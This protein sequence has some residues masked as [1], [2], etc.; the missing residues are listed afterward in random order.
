M[1]PSDWFLVELPSD[2]TPG[3]A[4]G[5]R[6]LAAKYA[7]IAEVAGEASDGVTRA[8]SSG[9]A[10]AWIGDAADV[11][12]E[13]S[14][15]M[16]GELAQAN[17]SY[18]VVAAALKVWADAVD[19][20]QAQADRGLQQ[21]RDAQ[22][23]RM[24]A[25]AVLASAQSS[26]STV[27][28]QQLTY[29]RLQKNYASVPPP[30]GVALPTPDQLR[31]AA[32][33]ASQ[34]QASIAT[35]QSR[36]ADADARLAAAR[37]LVLD[38]KARRDD[39]E[40]TIVHRI[41]EA[42]D[43]AVKPSSAWE[44]IQDSAAWQTL[45][46]VATVVLTIVSIVAIFVTGPLIW[47]IILAATLLLIVNAL[48]SIAQGKDAWGEF[49]LLVVGIIPG[50][51]LLGL[52]VRGLSRAGRAGVAVAHGSEL[53]AKAASR[54]IE[55]GS[56]IKSEIPTELQMVVHRLADDRGS[57]DFF[58]RYEDVRS[59]FATKFSQRS[60]SYDKID[61]ATHEPYTY[62][63]LAESMRSGGWQGKPINAVDLGHHG[64]TSLDNTRLMAARETNTAA[65]VVIHHPD[66]LLT[67]REIKRFTPFGSILKPETWG[68]ALDLRILNQK[69]PWASMNPYGTHELPTVTGRRS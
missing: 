11:F 59:P 12:R 55:I 30:A 42:E 62:D 4:F 64:V 57:I 24:S 27:H 36:I 14:Y 50:G 23:D 18:S 7:A 37:S 26:W 45:V 40:R 28:A 5:V 67:R 22:A 17:D 2:P 25:A 47:A 19:D 51:R 53:I 66:E 10:S 1:R 46:A 20:T 68:D 69:E 39:A 32:R 21:A 65:H 63:D 13:K 44:A 16:P 54:I 9:A 43:R 34:S 15:R 8:R 3:D 33:T 60:V 58:P 52:A 41:A 38:A 29:Q 56:A 48:L 35:A 31:S 6:G 61:R 49:A